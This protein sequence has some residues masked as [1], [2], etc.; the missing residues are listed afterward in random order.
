MIPDDV[1]YFCISMDR[2]MPNYVRAPSP[3]DT[4]MRIYLIFLI[5]QPRRNYILKKSWLN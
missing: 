2:A 1:E 3:K 5:D 4:D